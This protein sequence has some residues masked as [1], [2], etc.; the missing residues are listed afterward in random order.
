MLIMKPNGSL[1]VPSELKSHL[2]S[3]QATKGSHAPAP[4]DSR[5]FATGKTANWHPAQRVAMKMGRRLGKRVGGS[6]YCR[7]GVSASGK[8]AFRDGYNDHSFSF[9]F[10]KYSNI[11][12]LRADFCRC[13]KCNFSNLKLESSDETGGAR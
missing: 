13:A 4:G 6:A 1:L 8:T 12:W 2:R 3:K 11:D 7:I 10:S 9:R 5:V